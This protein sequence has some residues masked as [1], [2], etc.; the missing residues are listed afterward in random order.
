MEPGIRFR[1]SRIANSVEHLEHTSLSSAR[2]PGLKQNGAR[3]ASVFDDH[4][5]AARI[6]LNAL[7]STP[8]TPLSEEAT[9][10]VTHKSYICHERL[11][12]FASSLSGGGREHFAMKEMFVPKAKSKV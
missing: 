9:L 7:T 3:R 8:S 5:F 4:I 12:T 10:I 1:F 2:I 6:K 11:V